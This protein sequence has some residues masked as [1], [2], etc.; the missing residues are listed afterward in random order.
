MAASFWGSLQQ[1]ALV[2][3]ERLNELHAQDRVKGLT[4]DQLQQL[5]V[6][7]VDYMQQ[8][9]S[10]A[11][12]ERQQLLKMRVVATAAVYFRKF[13]LKTD[14]CFQEPRTLALACLFLASK[15]EETPI[16]AKLLL[17]Y[18][19]KLASTKGFHHPAGTRSLVLAEAK[20]VEQLDGD[21]LVFSPYPA[22]AKFLRAALCTL[23]KTERSAAAATAWSL[24]NDSY[25]T[26]L[27]LLHPPH[28]IALGCF[29]LASLLRGFDLQPWLKGLSADMNKVFEVS[30]EM[31]NFYERLRT[32][33][34][35]P[36]CQ[37]LLEVL[38][39]PAV[40]HSSTSQQAQHE[41]G[42]QAQQAQ[43]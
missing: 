43:G 26:P 4:D 10:L 35:T 22:L 37:R 33:I 27:A 21:L 39:L 32:P 18:A 8:V 11:Q 6:Y 14:F 30:K 3:K 38:G 41:L 23:S 17:H 24:V 29:H 20:L 36:T 15:T 40:L 1:K 16:H 5:Y 13:Y 28:I 31:L 9:A 42:Q 2:S 25:R 34:D 19:R 7:H 12:T